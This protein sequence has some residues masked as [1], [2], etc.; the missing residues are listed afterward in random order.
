MSSTDTNGA[1]RTPE[2]DDAYR[3][4]AEVVHKPGAVAVV[5]T[6]E[7]PRCGGVVGA[8]TCEDCL[9]PQPVVLRA[10]RYQV[11]VHGQQVTVLPDYTGK[12]VAGRGQ[13]YVGA[14]DRWA[15]KAPVRFDT[16]EE[17]AEAALR[18]PLEWV[19]DD[20]RTVGGEVWW[21]GAW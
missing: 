17:A 13:H 21:N 5:D 8:D 3:T 14:D 1:S 4:A 6:D 12:W 16:P 15:Y 10:V 7:C 9:W 11:T 18:A 2:G 19:N 20:G